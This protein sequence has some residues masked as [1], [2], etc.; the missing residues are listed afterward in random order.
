MELPQKIFRG[1]TLGGFVHDLP[2]MTKY[3]FTDSLTNASAYAIQYSKQFFDSPLLIALLD[4]KEFEL[5]YDGF[6][7]WKIRELTFPNPN[8]TLVGTFEYKK[9]L[10]QSAESQALF[11]DSLATPENP[12]VL[13]EKVLDNLFQQ[14]L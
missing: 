1:T 9:F 8:I 14:Y 10:R 5:D 13:V 2:I 7:A 12:P 6:G 4:T 11:L 3:K